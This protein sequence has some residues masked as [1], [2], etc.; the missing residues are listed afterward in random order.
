MQLSSL[1]DTM[2]PRTRSSPSTNRLA[3]PAGEF[4]GGAYAWVA[5]LALM[6]LLPLGSYVYLHKSLVDKYV[7]LE[8]HLI[9]EMKELTQLKQEVAGLSRIKDHLAITNGALSTAL[10]SFGHPLP[11]GLVVD[12]APDTHWYTNAP[13]SSGQQGL[14]PGAEGT[15]AD[16]KPGQQGYISVPEPLAVK[17]CTPDD[18]STDPTNPPVA[19]KNFF[20]ARKAPG[21]FVELGAGD[22][23]YES[24][25]HFLEKS[26]CWTGILVEPTNNEF[27]RLRAQRPRSVT[28]HGAVCPDSSS[29]S[30][31]SSSSEPFQDITLNGVWT[32]WSGFPA[33]FSQSHSA[34]VQQKV[35]EGASGGAEGGW[36]AVNVPVKCFTINALL[37]RQKVT[38]VDYMAVSVQGAEGGVLRSMDFNRTSVDVLDV[39]ISS[40][41]SQDV[42]ELKGFLTSKGFVF[43]SQHDVRSYIFLRKD[44]YAPDKHSTVL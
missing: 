31:S 7:R 17:D 24:P 10:R 35:K 13:P 16:L 39:D 4:P 41:S 42:Q 2:L 14:S 29:S 26:L 36:E 27:P 38:H 15:T 18:G 23:V 5:F 20:K 19:W 11:A 44:F 9:V 25:T 6:C 12:D 30:S 22:G 1:G 32:G 21:F 3:L 33:Y 37:E 43:H 8:K 40:R 28:V 34:A